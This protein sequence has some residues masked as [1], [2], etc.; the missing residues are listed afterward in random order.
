MK[1]HK[2]L[3]ALYSH[4]MECQINV[5]QGG[6]SKIQGEY[7]GRVW[8]GYTDGVQTW[9]PIRIPYNAATDPTY[10]DTPMTWSL[11][12]HAEAIGMTGWDWRR[13]LS[14]WVA[15]DF[16][17]I[18]GHKETHQKKL[19]P[20]EIEHIKELLSKVPWVT[21]RHSTGGLGLHVYV[22][23][24]PV[25]TE[26]HNEHAALARAI[27]GELAAVTGAQFDSQV[28]VC[29]GNMWVW[30]RKMRLHPDG[31][32]LIKRG[33]VLTDIPPLW[34]DHL[35]VVTGHRKRSLPKFLSEPQPSG[36]DAEHW[37]LELTSQYARIPLDDEHR[38]LIN[39]LKDF[40]AMSWW[41]QD[42]NMLITHTWFLKRAHEEL[43]LRGIFDTVAEG[44]ETPNDINCFMFPMSN[45][46]WSIRRYTMGC[47]E[48]PSWDQD[49]R[50]WTRCYF[51]MNPDLN[52]A[53]RAHQ[54]LEDPSGGYI[55]TEAELAIDTAR[56]LGAVVPEIPM[57]LRNQKSKI[58]MHKDGR[59]LLE[60][61]GDKNA[62][63]AKDMQG[64]LHDKGKWKRLF[65]AIH[66][67]PPEAEIISYDE[68][69]RHLI[70]ESGEDAGWVIRRSDS[71]GEEPLSHTI[72][73]L[74]AM[75]LGSKEV[76]NTIGSSVLKA[77]RLI[78]RPFQPE[79][80]GDR[81]WNRGAPQFKVI[82]SQKDDLHFPT[83]MKM[84]N[85]LGKGL[86]DIIAENGWAKANGITKGSDYLKIWI[87]S[88]FQKPSEPL[89]YLF[90]FSEQQNTGKS[91]FHEALSLLM[92]KGYINA[93]TALT[94]KGNF[95]GELANM[96]LCYIEEIDL[97]KE[98]EAAN[99]MKE[100]VTARELLIHPKNGTPYQQR[101]TTHWCQFSNNR[102]YCPVFPGDSRI[103]VIRVEDLMP[104]ERIPK[105]Q[106]LSMLQAEAPDFLAEILKTEI[107][108]SNDRLNVP[109]I[110]TADKA[111]AAMMNRTAVE[112]FF[113]ER[114]HHVS[115]EMIRYG[116]IY[117]RFVEWADAQD[118]MYWTKR[119][120]GSAIP[121]KY[122]KGRSP[123]NGQIYIG[124]V[125]WTP[126]R[127]GE[128]KPRL[129]AI[130][131]GK[132]E[133]FLRPEKNNGVH[134]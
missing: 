102:E 18:I 119:K 11:E 124:N 100:W 3:A 93:N 94:S 131:D 66:A 96:I 65:N 123:E 45:G 86:D 106:M 110:L 10:E 92:T 29:G 28:D 116:E 128:T 6:G 64:W 40:K 82:P 79:Y 52:M 43:K 32:R 8:H 51:N 74:E 13:R 41:D 21:L 71:W 35:K 2:D 16:D 130:S 31:L 34:K 125:S 115:G 117:D 121:T 19:T 101:N 60:V 44:K 26:N 109:V 98:K 53:A 46:A 12:E 132:G 107:P 27:L 42:H 113:E 129:K 111:D 39:W 5:A 87:A 99:K 33:T 37:F 85:H 63:A 133:F 25:L 1:T 112:Q 50:G 80:P 55:F 61:E 114:V 4:D 118:A 134:H 30:H 76:R 70:A 68:N 9:K 67:A 120:F 57:G 23:L 7:R 73:V 89:P 127:G 78:N 54:G 38:R 81:L 97:Q 72:K 103:T 17:S 105:S 126:F 69:V 36:Q 62:V 22:F 58:R 75:G 47:G 122:P 49:G 91:T 83:W 20:E 108:P 84:L 104:E 48:K 77:W 59:L 90:F 24:Q 88:M 56:M 95:N 14:R 15:F